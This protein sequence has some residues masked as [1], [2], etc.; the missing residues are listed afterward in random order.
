MSDDLIS[1]SA[2]LKELV[3]DYAYAAADIVKAA[4]TVDAVEVVRCKDCK[5]AMLWKNPTDGAIGDCKIRVWSSED[6][7][8][9][10]V[11]AGDF[12]SYGERR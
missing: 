8:F 7:Y 9:C 5:H 3:F 6:K 2:L 11:G 12:C 10:M 4:P 1:R